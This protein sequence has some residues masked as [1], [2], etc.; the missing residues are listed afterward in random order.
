MNYGVWWLTM[1]LKIRHTVLSEPDLS[2]KLLARSKKT[3]ALPTEIVRRALR[4]YLKRA[5]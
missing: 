5:K 2:K 4:A 3:G 1:R